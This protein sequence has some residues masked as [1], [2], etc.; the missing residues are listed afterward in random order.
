MCLRYDLAIMLPEDDREAAHLLWV[1]VGAALVATLTVAIV[2]A[3]G[4][5]IS[6]WLGTPTLSRI[7]GS[8]GI[9]ALRR[10]FQRAELWKL[11]H[12]QIRQTGRRAGEC[13]RRQS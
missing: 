12:S 1:S 3:G 9:C 13:L 2:G 11:P 7:F 5:T 10:G 8:L 4:S 6:A